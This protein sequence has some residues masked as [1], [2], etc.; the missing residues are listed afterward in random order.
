MG[1]LQRWLW[2]RQLGGLEAPPG[3]CPSAS[4][5]V[6]DTAPPGS[7]GPHPGLG[8]RGLLQAPSCSL[9]SYERGWE[10]LEFTTLTGANLPFSMGASP[11]PAPAWHL[12]AR[13]IALEFLPLLFGS[14]SVTTPGKPSV[15]GEPLRADF[16]SSAGRRPGERGALGSKVPA[17]PP[18]RV[19]GGQRTQEPS[20]E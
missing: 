6:L 19:G 10:P 7:W 16:R 2:G 3:A 13:G 18:S 20:W 1:D 4:P 8:A 17:A 9:S 15:P 11:A 14:T 5:C 12:G